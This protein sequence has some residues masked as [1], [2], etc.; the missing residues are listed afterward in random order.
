MRQRRESRTVVRLQRP[1]EQALGLQSK[2]AYFFAAS[3]FGF[4]VSFF[5]ALLPLAMT[6]SVLDVARSS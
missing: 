4:F 5:R 1:D 6:S 2:H 3:F